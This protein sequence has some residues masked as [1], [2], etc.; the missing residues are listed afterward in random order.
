HGGQAP[1]GLEAELLL[2]HV[3]GREV[4]VDGEVEL[5][6]G[7]LAQLLPLE[8]G[9]GL[10]DHLDVQVVADGRNVSRLVLT[11]EVAGAADLEVAHGDLEAR[12]ELGV[13]ADRLEALVGLFC[14]RPLGR[15]EEVGVRP[16]PGAAHAAPQLM[17]LTEAHKV[18]AVDDE[19]VDRRHVDA[20]L[21]DRRADED[22][23]LALPEVEHDLL[24]HGLVHL[25]M[26]DGNARFGHELLEAR[27]HALDVLHSVVHEE[28][29]AFTQ[30]LT[31]DR[32]AYGTL[33]VL[34]DVGE[35]RH[36]LGGW[37]VQQR[38]V[39]DPGEAHLE[40]ARD[41]RGGQREYV[42]VDLELLDVLLVG[43]AEALFLV[44]NEQPK[45]LELDVATEKT[46]RADD[47]VNL[48]ALQPLH[49]LA[50]LRGR[51]EPGQDLDAH[52]IA[53]EALGERLEVLLGEQSRGHQ[54]G[55]LLAVLHGLEGG[56]DGYLGLA[57]A[58][59]A[60]D[61]AVHRRR[62]LHVGLH[63]GDRRELIG[64]LLVREA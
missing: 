54:H 2:G 24:E 5:D 18:G 33:V 64:R 62:V 17:Q 53:G 25:P 27:R 51:E 22:V 46:V 36:A 57:K 63:V 61:E 38:E 7:G 20:R 21:D 40:G 55:N 47:N 19:R 9:D 4:G 42:D 34:A 26:G 50:R 31:P 49:H 41:W 48:A 52:R 13:L 1:V 58:H 35:D 6:L 39:A 8:L 60:A 44:D 10:A 59:V 28:D 30:Q 43:D 32:F 14:Q 29:L 45:V 15:E 16:L 11:E 37:R 12:P 56:A 23:V 3:V